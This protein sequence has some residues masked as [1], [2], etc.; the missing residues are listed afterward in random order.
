MPKIYSSIEKTN[1]RNSL[2]QYAEYALKTK[3]V[4]ATSIDDIIAE[5]GIA[6]GSF[7]LFYSSKEELFFSSMVNFRREMDFKLNELLLNLD[8]NH[9][10]KSVSTIFTTL[11]FE[12]YDRGMYRFYD[13]QEYTLITRKID[14][15]LVENEKKEML[16][17]FKSLLKTFY[18]EK[19]VEPFY[20]AFVLL[21]YSL[22]NADKIPN[23]KESL[24]LI[25]NGLVYN[26]ID[27]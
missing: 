14:P 15:V 21:I 8:E 17:L 10:V 6:K 27:A 25:I 7:Y 5:V 1:I 26:L 12:L 24:R 19:G 13:K 23:L 3:G 16:N 2:L 9:I 22:Q 4:K 20:E 11:I 18:I